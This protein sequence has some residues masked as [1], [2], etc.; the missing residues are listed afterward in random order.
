M[1]PNPRRLTPRTL[2]PE[3]PVVSYPTPNISDLMVVQDVDTR[4]PGYVALAYG[5]LHPDQVNYPGLKLVF[6]QPLDQEAN[7]MWV[8]RIYAKDRA[9]QDEYNY[10]VKFSA[11]DPG[12]PIYVRTYILPRADY[13]PLSKGAQDPEYPTATLVNEEVQ[14]IKSNTTSDANEELLDSLFVKVIRIFE[15][16]PG[17]TIGAKRVYNER[18]DLETV[19]KQTVDSDSAPTADGLLVTAAMVEQEDT[20]KGLKTTSTVTSHSTLRT[21]KRGNAD[22]IPAKF[23]AAQVTEATDDIVAPSTAPEVPNDTIVESQVQQTSATKAKKVTVSLTGAVS[24]LGGKKYT[25]QGQI[26]TVTESLI[27][28][29]GTDDALT[30]SATTVEANI[31]ALGNGKSV[32]TVAE[33]SS[34]FGEQVFSKERPD[35]TPEKFRALVPALTESVVTAGTA[36]AP[37][38][39]DGDLSKTEEQITV[40]KKRTRSTKR[41]VTSAATLS[42]SRIT[43]DGQLAQVVET[44]ATGNQTVTPSATTVEGRVEALGNGQTVKT[45]IT[46]SEVFDRKTFSASKPEVLPT[47]FRASVPTETTV[48]VLAGTAATMPALGVGELEASE[49][50]VTAHT[51]RVSK[52]KRAITNI[53]TLRGQS[54]DPQTNTVAKF[55]EQITNSGNSL[56]DV[57]KEV[58]PLSSDLD[59]VR[60]LDLTQIGNELSSIYL[61]FPSRATL[62]L[63]PVLKSLS[64]VW[65]LTSNVGNYS[66]TYSGVNAGLS[67]S[68]RANSSAARTPAWVVD[69]EQVWATNVPTTTHVF[70]LKYPFTIQN[71]LTKVGGAIQWP[72]F[73]PQSH[74]LVAWGQ[75]V[76]VNAEAS[77]NNSWSQA[78]GFSQVKGQGGGAQNASQAVVLKL[79]PCLHGALNVSDT[80]SASV[81]A[82]VDLTMPTITGFTKNSQGELTGLTQGTVSLLQKTVTGTAIGSVQGTL[83][84][85]S[86]TNIPRSGKYLID[87]K[88]EMYKYGYAKVYAEVIDASIFA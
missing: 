63:P 80:R 72:T 44:L 9:D 88:V 78:L 56:G 28:T 10:A 59:L 31:E 81:N 12:Y 60:T 39:E 47:N 86:P 87:S 52:T 49:Q 73:K 57:G 65:D 58:S 62:N 23:R 22:L 32:K 17:P 4:V 70:F 14:R 37:T 85:T 77:I 2:T 21:K 26:A 11:S 33:V 67:L 18:G 68:G 19:V 66:N 79:P 40:Q 43:S 55:T 8:R 25:P 69:L 75:S 35:V 1:P 42:S 50:R 84:A 54:Y 45:E 13:E 3:N 71:I 20:S 83:T 30:P 82:T 61:T 7:F 64:V 48:E 24:P 16:I 46:V 29:G 15:T 38:L 36:V 5:D 51:K 41:I 74:N 76:G 27:S 6:Q 53:P 34:V